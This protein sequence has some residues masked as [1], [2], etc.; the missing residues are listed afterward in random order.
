LTG[1]RTLPTIGLMD[2]QPLG[3]DN[4][5]PQHIPNAPSIYPTATTGIGAPLTPPPTPNPVTVVSPPIIN[6]PP[7]PTPVVSTPANEPGYEYIS[8]PFLNAARGLVLILKTNPAPALLSGLIGILLYVLYEIIYFAVI[9]AFKSPI[10]VLLFIPILILLYLLVLGS[11]FVI[12]GASARNE[13]VSTGLAFKKSLSKLIPMV[14]LTILSM[15]MSLSFILLIVPGLYIMARGS[16]SLMVMLEEN[17]G[18]I[19]SI[20]RSFS[21]T[22]G[23]VNEMLGSY[24]AGLFMGSWSLL[25]GASAVAPITGRYSDLRKLEE[26]NAPKPPTHWLNYLYILG[27]VAI[28]GLIVA[29]GSSGTL[30]PTQPG[31]GEC[32][33]GSNYA[34]IAI[35]GGATCTTAESIVQAANGSNFSSNGY[36]CTATKGGSNTSWASYWSGNTYYIYACSNGSSQVAF[37]WI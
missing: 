4:P 24:T 19:K 17:L 10:L 21:L 26:T 1:V 14:G 29:T 11:Y 28:V 32:G 20:K 23:H 6:A 18:P 2:N 31:A 22:K 3:E 13:E 5:A 9:V 7:Q 15:L 34:Q 33:A 27:V 30:V 25:F 8:N 16:L 36:S 35:S 12:G 37:T